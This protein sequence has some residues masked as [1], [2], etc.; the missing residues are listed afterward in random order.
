MGKTIDLSYINFSLS[1]FHSLFKFLQSQQEISNLK[2]KIYNRSLV[3]YIAKYVSLIHNIPEI[4]VINYDSMENFSKIN[5]IAETER[6]TT[7]KKT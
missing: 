3:S 6:T 7:L 5:Y 1:D 4:E 2:I